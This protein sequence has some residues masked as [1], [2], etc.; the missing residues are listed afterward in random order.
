MRRHTHLAVIVLINLTALVGL[1]QTRSPAVGH[2]KEGTRNLEQ[3][4]LDSA[5]EDFTQ[6][7]EISSRLDVSHAS[8]TKPG[9]GESGFDNSTSE[10][11]R[12]KVIDPLPA[13]AYISRGLARK[14]QGDLEGALADWERAIEIHPGLAA[15]YINRGYVR[16]AKGDTQG[17]LSDWSRAAAIDP[18][19][20]DAFANRGALLQEMGDVEGA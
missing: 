16:L 8:T 5:I 1:A 9:A 2:Y 4:N 10:A 20:A 17:A 15:A 19:L 7:I 13:N 11:K 6:A 12:I 3:G 18:N 14:K